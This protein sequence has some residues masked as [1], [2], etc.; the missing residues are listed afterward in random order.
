MLTQLKN[1]W[2]D[3]EGATAIEYG[4]IVGLI[5]VV[6]I[7]SVSLLGETLKGFFDTIQT[8]LSAEAP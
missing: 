8:E 2:L 6:I 5:A 4:L 1:F 3:E 7:G